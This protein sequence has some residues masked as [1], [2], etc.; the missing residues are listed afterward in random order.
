V[1]S[2]F[3]FSMTTVLSDLSSAQLLT[4]RAFQSR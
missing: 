3:R 4:T 2:S 1:S